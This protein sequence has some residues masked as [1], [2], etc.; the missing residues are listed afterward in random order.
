MMISKKILVVVVLAIVLIVTIILWGVG[1]NWKFKSKSAPGSPSCKPKCDGVA[2]GGKDG[3]GATCGCKKGQQCTNGKCTTPAKQSMLSLSSNVFQTAVGSANSH[4]DA[5]NLHK[6]LGMKNFDGV[7][8]HYASVEYDPFYWPDDFKNSSKPPILTG[9]L[10]WFWATLDLCAKDDCLII[11]G[12]FLSFD[13]SVV[14]KICDKV[15]KGMKLII[16]VDRWE[17]SGAPL[18]ES[19]SG[20]VWSPDNPS[21]LMGTNGCPVCTQFGCDDKN[22]GNAFDSNPY[23]CC[24]SVAGNNK[25][26]YCNDTN[27][28]LLRFS[29]GIT[30]KDNFFLLD[31]A[32]TKLTWGPYSSRQTPLHNHRH[33]TSFYLPSQ[34][35][36]SVF[37]GSWN[38]TGGNPNTWGHSEIP[39]QKESGIIVTAALKNA[40]IQSDIVTNYYWLAVWSLFVPSSSVT[41]PESFTKPNSKLF[42]Y[43]LDK[44]IDPKYIDQKNDVL[45]YDGYRNSTY[46]VYSVATHGG[47]TYLA[48]DP[49]CHISFAVSPPPQDAGAVS[50]EL[51]ARSLRDGDTDTTFDKIWPSLQNISNTNQFM[52][53]FAATYKNN[54][55]PPSKW[56]ID[57][58]DGN[59]C[60]KAENGDLGKACLQTDS[61][62]GQMVPTN[63]C[64]QVDGKSY[65]CSAKMPWAPG[66][67]WIGGVMFDFWKGAKS[68]YVNM[69]SSMVDAGQGCI[70]NCNNSGTYGGVSLWPGLTTSDQ[71]NDGKFNSKP[72]NSG[73]WFMQADSNCIQ[74]VL[75]FLSKKDNKLFIIAGQWSNL[76]PGVGTNG[77]LEMFSNVATQSGSS[78]NYKLFSAQ[79]T[80]TTLTGTPGTVKTVLDGNNNPNPTNDWQRNHTKCYLTEDSLLSCSG[81]PYNGGVNDWA[82]VNEALFVE[83]CPNFVSILRANFEYEYTYAN[84]IKNSSSFDWAK[85]WDNESIPSLDSKIDPTQLSIG[86]WQAGS[87]TGG[88]I[89]I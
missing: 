11:N 74:N 25:G 89:T 77:A 84:T 22:G 26:S 83:K 82:G 40:A 62:S 27:S 23:I 78:V 47:K 17:I 59:N 32:T 16:L 29:Q 8:M 69:Y 56:R 70:L 50:P 57:S 30:A 72:I 6:T 64:Y 4:F 52:Y 49:Q 44:L 31:M 35:V 37:K 66:A 61:A 46:E 45:T 33:L 14:Q 53:P 28:A 75:D 71:Y 15:N 58:T 80:Q 87:T 63:G 7:L 42:Q 18:F 38:F 55:V 51:L 79:K 13:S 12:D 60:T 9:I 73:G 54:P 76:N 39:G 67:L 3:C 36:A 34:G 68:V 10:D 65:R 1:T 5:V 88:I 2:C 21:N 19:R 86:T 41:A 24:G 85:D 81:H 43:F 20:Q 48:G